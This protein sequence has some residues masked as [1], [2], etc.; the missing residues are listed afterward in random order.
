[1]ELVLSDADKNHSLRR[2]LVQQIKFCR[3]RSEVRF[4]LDINCN[5][6]TASEI[7]MA[8]AVNRYIVG[9][10]VDHTWTSKV[11]QS[12]QIWPHLREL[13]LANMTGQKA[14][15]ATLQKIAESL[16]QAENLQVFTPPSFDSAKVSDSTIAA[17]A[18]LR[19]HFPT[20]RMNTGRQQSLLDC[21]VAVR[22]IRNEEAQKRVVSQQF[23][24]VDSY[25]KGDLVNVM[26]IF[27]DLK[28]IAQQEQDRLLHL[29]SLLHDKH[30]NIGG[31]EFLRE[32]PEDFDTGH[33]VP[34]LSVGPEM[35]PEDLKS[36]MEEEGLLEVVCHK[37]VL[38]LEGT[39]VLQDMRFKQSNY[40]CDG[41]PVF[42]WKDSLFLYRHP[43]GAWA[44]AGEVGSSVPLGLLRDESMAQKPRLLPL[45][46]T[47]DLE[48][49]RWPG[50]SKL[51]WA[52]CDEC[53]VFFKEVAT[54]ETYLVDELQKFLEMR[55]KDPSLKRLASLDEVKLY[56]LKMGPMKD[57]ARAQQKA[58]KWL[59]DVNRCTFVT[60]SP[61]VLALIYYLIE[62]K[63]KSM[64]GEI[65]RRSNHII[66]KDGLIKDPKK[67]PCV[68]LNLRIPQKG[69]TFEVMITLQ[70][71]ATAKEV[72][73]KY[74]E[75]TRCS[76]PLD[77]MAP[78]FWAWASILIGR[79][80][81]IH[82]DVNSN[83]LELWT[84]HG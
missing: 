64:N 15:Q 16:L 29:L 67:P 37:R 28:N 44:L 60:D 46:E 84:F 57:F 82:C 5:E 48:Q 42:C 43:Q 17:L 68:H 34:W 70:D 2:K 1:M 76:S 59:L 40:F 53:Q 39:R 41:F 4:R 63:T 3:F 79:S 62:S 9:L 35:R 25:K 31:Y 72:L 52:E 38:K 10:E 14:E 12:L 75:I 22:A 13:S 50:A 11:Q 77:L 69:W 73:H 23:N 83:F 33:R 27:R 26:T 80:H 24:L 66:S 55:M 49:W 47:G 74:Y 32:L 51:W 30:C 61:L 18:K 71:F 8:C 58:A 36:F 65:S 54:K 20:I 56:D 45:Y 19:F 21:R 7:V 78:I 81:W 6:E